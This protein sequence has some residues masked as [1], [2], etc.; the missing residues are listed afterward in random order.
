MLN[1]CERRREA[2]AG[3]VNTPVLVIDPP[4]GVV[5]TPTIDPP[6]VVID[7]PAGVVNTPTTD[8][9]NVVID[10]PAPTVVVHMCDPTTGDRLRYCKCNK[11]VVECQDDQ[12]VMCSNNKCSNSRGQ[13]NAN[14]F[15]FECVGFNPNVDK[16]Y[17]CLD[18]CRPAVKPAKKQRR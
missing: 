18:A 10:P 6:T 11:L 12:M 15:H 8:P 13:H 16:E 1:D 4:A 17:Y 7:P 14:W 9:P 5:N 3:D 2:V